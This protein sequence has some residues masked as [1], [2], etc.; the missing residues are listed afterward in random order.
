M[1]SYRR[2]YPRRYRPMLFWNGA[3]AGQRT[4]VD[5]DHLHVRHRPNHDD[6]RWYFDRAHVDLLVSAV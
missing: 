1:A 5:V 4:T 2:D 6:H 3:V